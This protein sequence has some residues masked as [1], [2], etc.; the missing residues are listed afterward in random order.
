MSRYALYILCVLMALLSAVMTLWLDRGWLWA[1]VVFGALAAL[2]TWDLL[3][4]RSTL[5]RN[6][7]V[8]AHFRY[9]LES[10]GPVM[11]Q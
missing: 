7:P 1:L 5:R 11:R 3:Q 9:G 6:Y 10:I 2:G 8:L 4:R